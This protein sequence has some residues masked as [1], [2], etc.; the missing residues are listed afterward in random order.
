MTLIFRRNISDAAALAKIADTLSEKWAI[1]RMRQVCE[2]LDLQQLPV[3][4]AGSRRTAALSSEPS[5]L[6]GCY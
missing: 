6:L 3:L 2:R 4:R 1:G 5:P